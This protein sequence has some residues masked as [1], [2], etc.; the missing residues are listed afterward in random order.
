MGGCMAAAV[1]HANKPLH[2]GKK[3]LEWRNIRQLRGDGRRLAS[4]AEHG[5]C[6]SIFVPNIR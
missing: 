2:P 1:V 6:G 4:I 5:L 3:S